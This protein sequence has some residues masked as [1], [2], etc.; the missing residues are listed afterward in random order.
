MKNLTW[1]NAYLAKKGKNLDTL[2]KAIV[3]MTKAEIMERFEGFGLSMDHTKNE[4]LSIILDSLLWEGYR[5]GDNPFPEDGAEEEAEEEIIEETKE[6]VTEETTEETTEAASTGKRELLVIGPAPLTVVNPSEILEEHVTDL[7]TIESE[8]V[9][10]TATET[11]AKSNRLPLIRFAVTGREG[12][13]LAEDAKTVCRAIGRAVKATVTAAPTIARVASEAVSTGLDA[14]NSLYIILRSILVH[15]AWW[16][17]DH[18]SAMQAGAWAV[19]RISG[20][21][22]LSVAMA[23]TTLALVAIAGTVKGAHVAAKAAKVTARECAAGWEMRKEILDEA[24]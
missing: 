20:R 14:V 15:L 4:M 2:E 10:E 11:K 17:Q 24:A 21:V 23:I 1:V 19:A 12:A 22:A 9:N 16:V 6:E 3:R 18:A 7:V 8:S 5:Y 13:E